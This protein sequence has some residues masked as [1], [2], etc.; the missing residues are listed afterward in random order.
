MLG[1]KYNGTCLKEETKPKLNHEGDCIK[2]GLV[3]IRNSAHL[4]RIRRTVVKFHHEK[5]YSRKRNVSK[6]VLDM[7]QATIATHGFNGWIGICGG[8]DL[9][10]EAL[11]NQRPKK[12]PDSKIDM[13]AWCTKLVADG[14]TNRKQLLMMAAE[15]EGLLLVDQGKDDPPCPTGVTTTDT[16]VSCISTISKDS[17]ESDDNSR[18]LL[19]S[20]V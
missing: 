14:V 4:Q 2:H 1:L 15:Q 17:V 19:V 10:T 5:I 3:R 16:G 13:L 20:A 7:I 9:I 8:H 11:V 18:S 6:D 12:N